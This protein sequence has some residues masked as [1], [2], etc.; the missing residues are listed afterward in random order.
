MVL[1]ILTICKNKKEIVDLP[2]PFLLK[3]YKYNL[4]IL[5]DTVVKLDCCFKFL[6]NKKQS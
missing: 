1:M 5:H 6:E 4:S 2:M 3:T